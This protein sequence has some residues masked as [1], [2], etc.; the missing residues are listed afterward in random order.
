MRL[1]T[2]W[3]VIA[4]LVAAV[5]SADEAV[6]PP[7]DPGFLRFVERASSYYPDSTFRVVSEERKR[8]PSGSYRI[9]EVDRS[10]AID[11]LSG[12]RTV[13]VDDVADLAWFGNAARLPLEETG[14]GIDALRGFLEGFLPDAL[15]SAL[16]MKVSLDWQDPPFRAGA[17]LSFWLKVD[18]GYGEYRKVASVT[19][20]G[21][22]LV[23]GPVY[24]LDSDPVTVRR[25]FLASDELVIWDRV[26]PGDA[27][28]EIVEFSDLECPACSHRWPLIKEIL[29]ANRS[30]VRHGMVSLPLS[31][32]HP[33]SFRAA[34]ATW[35]VSEQNSELLL[36][37]KELFY[38]L[39]TEME[40]GLVTPTSRDFVAGNGLDE[41]AF[42]Q[43]YLRQPSLD[44]VHGQL[45]IG[46]D[47]G[48]VST[49]T[50]VVNGWIVQAIDDEWFP[51]FIKLLA[52]GEE[53]N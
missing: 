26:P 28:V 23:L 34:C 35:C 20:D 6:S 30:T 3:G 9:V 33:W 22:F 17:L 36:P 39:Q 12:S 11:L 14:M 15:K 47:L 42:N 38:E 7:Q 52:A 49:P 18:T 43:C 44:A 25:E 40:V 46:Q 24:A 45:K 53:P 48:V 2:L 29:D 51:D 21:G 32:I 5:A 10:C 19:A 27:A 31:V 4:V 16:Q 37:F 1:K 13:V 50:Y 41:E 8:T